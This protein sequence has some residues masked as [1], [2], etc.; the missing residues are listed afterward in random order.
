MG[1]L[2]RQRGAEPDF[3]Q[4]GAEPI[5]AAMVGKAGQPAD[6]RHHHITVAD[7]REVGGDATGL[8][9][10]IGRP[11]RRAGEGED[12]GCDELGPW[13][14]GQKA[15]GFLDGCDRFRRM[16]RTCS[17][18]ICPNRLHHAAQRRRAR[19]F[20]E[21]GI[22]PRDIR[23]AAAHCRRR[24]RHD[25]AIAGIGRHRQ[26]I[27]ELRV[28]CARCRQQHRH[29]PR[30]SHPRLPDWP[31]STPCVRARPSAPYRATMK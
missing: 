16:L 27:R 9:P 25:R 5:R 31:H 4:P 17:E 20:G 1:T 22:E 23:L 2:G 8:H 21:H 10:Q 30:V 18:H 29:D 12:R 13:I 19:Q 24:F 26:R 14:V 7:E 3:A 15:Q 11:L 28:S 6:Q